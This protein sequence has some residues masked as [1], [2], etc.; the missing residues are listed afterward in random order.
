MELLTTEQLE[1][2][3]SRWFDC[4][5]RYKLMGTRRTFLGAYNIILE[6]EGN[7]PRAL[8]PGAWVD[9]SRKYHWRE[10]AALWDREQRMLD[11]TEFQDR[12]IALKEKRIAALEAHLSKTVQAIEALDPGS[13]DFR[14]VSHALGI[15]VRELRAELEPGVGGFDLLGL[16]EALPADLRL[17]IVA[18]LRIESGASTLEPHPIELEEMKYADTNDGSH[19]GDQPIPD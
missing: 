17:T 15:C 2:E 4:F 19:H 1:N 18:A 9:A 13:T 3:P 12:R 16:L 14:S 7:P 11:E 5:C 10:R 6:E 8:L